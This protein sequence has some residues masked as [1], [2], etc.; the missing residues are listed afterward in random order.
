MSNKAAEKQ[1]TTG[2]LTG[3]VVS[4]KAQKTITVS[5][6]RI[7]KHPIY[8][9]T[10]RIKKQYLAHD[11]EN[12]SKPGDLVRIRL[13]RPISRRKKWLLQEILSS[14]P[15]QAPDDLDNEVSK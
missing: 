1:K 9:K 10:V 15:G 11:E 7:F 13:V 4:S 14:T 5:V 8:Q 3:V 2:T 12:R 6:E